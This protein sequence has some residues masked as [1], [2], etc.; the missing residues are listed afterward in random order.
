MQAKHPLVETV[1][2]YSKHLLPPSEG[3]HI[4]PIG[5]LFQPPVRQDHE[6][7]G[8]SEELVR[9]LDNGTAPIYIGWGSMCC[10]LEYTDRITRAAVG[11]LKLANK[12]GVILA[13]W[14]KL[15]M[16]CLDGDDDLR[17]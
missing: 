16:S 4:E 1:F 8:V 3:L 12:R 14:Q 13:G 5:Y 11:A 6:W 7:F 17:S 2:A 15:S 10:G 9:F